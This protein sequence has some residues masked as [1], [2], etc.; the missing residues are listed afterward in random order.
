MRD[1]LV[2][3]IVC[4]VGA[5]A[6]MA[7]LAAGAHVSAQ[8]AVVN[9]CVA[10]SGSVRI[11]SAS[12]TCRGNE[13]RIS[14]NVQGAA[15]PAGREGPAGPAGPTGQAGREG[16]AGPEGLAG[17]DG[18]DG[19]DAEA[20]PAATPTVTGRLTITGLPG[21]PSGTVS[22]IFSFGTQA[23]N[24]TVV[25]GGGGG[26]VGKV[27]FSDFVIT[28]PL[29]AFS[30][31]LL[32]AAAEGRHIPAVQIEIFEVGSATPFATY[33]LKDA[34]VTADAFSSSAMGVVENVSFSYGR[35]EATINL[36]GVVYESCYD[37]VKATAC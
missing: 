20:P 1:S 24:S 14:W 26:G 2:K 28:K 23:T 16:S 22:P 19:R 6:A 15:G 25:G 27:D 31:P 35:I 36:G 9:A 4:A 10:A 30:A 11:V 17:R 8:G 32:Q 37:R 21:I 7:V 29:D 33:F 3:R 18:R 34:V 5:S 13:N 12:D